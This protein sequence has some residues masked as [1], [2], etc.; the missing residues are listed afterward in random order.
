[1]Q[2]TAPSWLKKRL[3]ISD[4]FFEMKRILKDSSIGTV[5]E[6]SLCPNI[7]ECFSRKRATFLILGETCTR[8][9]GFCSVKKGIARTPDTKEP[10]RISGLV[11]RLDLKYVVITSVTR[12][13]LDDGGAS[14]FV[15]V[16]E[17]VRRVSKDIKIE[18]L[19]PDFK[20]EKISVEAIVKA[21]PNVFS[22]NIETVNRLYP[23][24]RPGFDYEQSLRVLRMAKEFAPWQLTKSGLMVGLSETV[25]EVVYTMKDL[26]AA[27]C[28]IL[29][30][31]QYLRPTKS[32]LPV[33]KFVTPEE[34]EWYEGVGKGFGF[35]CVTSGP[36]VRSSYLAEEAYKRLEEVFYGERCDITATS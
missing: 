18:V 28:D 31:G 23:V 32:N 14:Q 3:I 30:I 10:E 15:K 34:F 33:K 26:K 12:D 6:S 2:Q 22:H 17:A 7:S 11:K 9:C 1:M 24:V 5:C 36:F 19:I 4:D 35:K 25:E 27:G 29:T 16:I 21:R 20:G 13:D 8:Q